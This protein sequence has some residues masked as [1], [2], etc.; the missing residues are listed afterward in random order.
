MFSYFDEVIA[1]V[2][3]CTLYIRNKLIPVHT[4]VIHY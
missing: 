3:Y 4:K 2:V 1:I